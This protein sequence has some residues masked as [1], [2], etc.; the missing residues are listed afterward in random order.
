[1]ATVPPLGMIRL[2]AGQPTLLDAV[3]VALTTAED[4]QALSYVVTMTR[5]SLEMGDRQSLKAPAVS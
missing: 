1:M 2:T 4:L 5:A 3:A